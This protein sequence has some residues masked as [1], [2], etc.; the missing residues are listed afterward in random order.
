MTPVNIIQIWQPRYKDRKVLIAKYKV[1]QMNQIEFT[2]AKHLEGMKFRMSGAEI[3][4]H[5]VEDNGK[6]ACYAVPMDE[7]KRHE[8]INS[9][10]T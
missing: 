1:G 6:I 8:E 7:L 5:P 4:K 3:Q 10:T 9:F 2:K